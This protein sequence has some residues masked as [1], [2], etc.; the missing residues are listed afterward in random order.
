MDNVRIHKQKHTNTVENVK[1]SNLNSVEPIH[2]IGLY[3]VLTSHIF[4]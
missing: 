3:K 4:S 2:N 1:A